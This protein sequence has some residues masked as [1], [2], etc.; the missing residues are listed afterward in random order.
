[1]IEIQ[2]KCHSNSRRKMY[3]RLIDPRFPFFPNPFLYPTQLTGSSSSGLPSFNQYPF[4]LFNPIAFNP[5]QLQ[6]AA[7]LL[8]SLPKPVK[9]QKPPYSYIALIA[10][11]IRAAPEQKVTLSGIYKFIIDK[12]PYY[13]ENKQ[14]W[15]NSIRHNLSLNDCFLKIP[16]EKGRP[17]KGN[18]WTLDPNCD[19]MFE[20]GNFR[21]RKRKAKGGRMHVSEPI[22]QVQEYR[23]DHEGSSRESSLSPDPEE[24]QQGS[25]EDSARVEVV[26]A[27]PPVKRPSL[28]FSIDNLIS[29]KRKAHSESN[30]TDS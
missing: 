29:N 21:R 11:A 8:E 15:Q 25:G 16:R 13:H 3:G 7:S 26:Y 23:L 1:M 18:Y 4:P 28:P 24:E 17:G 6:C 30:S 12:F 5:N 19:E 10:M 27:E 9:H 22:T 20:N 2:P 14:G